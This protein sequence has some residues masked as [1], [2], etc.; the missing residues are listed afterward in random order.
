MQRDLHLKSNFTILIDN[1]GKRTTVH[2]YR[3]LNVS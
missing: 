2:N 3:E 1:Y